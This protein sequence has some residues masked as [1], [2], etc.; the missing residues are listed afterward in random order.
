MHVN[1][2]R[3]RERIVLND[4]P[5]YIFC[6]QW[7][8]LS[9]VLAITLLVFSISPVAAQQSHVIRHHGFQEFSKGSFGD[10]GAN[11]YVSRNGLIQLIPRWDLNQDGYLDLLFNQD[12]NLIENVDAFIHWGRPEGY[13]SL[14][15]AFRKEVPAFKLVRTLQQRNQHLSFLPTFGGGSVKLVDLNRDDYVDIVFPNTIHNYYVDLDAY[16][17]WGGPKGYSSRRRTELPTLFAGDVAVADLNR[18][19]YPDLVFANYGD[20][21]GDRFGYKN[22]RYSYIYWGAPDGFSVQ[23][24]DQIPTLS[25]R[26]CTAGD[27]NGD[28]WPDLAFAN[29]SAKH[30]SLYVYLGGREGYRSNSRVI[31]EGGDPRVVRSADLNADGCSELIV[32]SQQ[33]MSNVYYGSR[34][35]QLKKPLSLPASNSRDAVSA[36]FNRDGHLDIAFASGANKPH[37]HA[38]GEVDATHAPLET[39]SVIFW[40]SAEGFDSRR[41]TMLPTLSPAAV[42][43]EDL[44]DDGYPEV[45][46]ANEHDGRT[47]DVPSYIYWGSEEGFDPSNRKHLQGFG[48]VGIGAADLNGDKRPEVVLMNPLSGNR[49]GLRSV[50][51]WGNRAHRYSEANATLLHTERPYFSKVADFND[52]GFRTWCFLGAP[53]TSTGEAH[54]GSNDIRCST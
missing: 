46:F 14:F 53:S 18:D 29:N 3:N 30:K 44:N 45:I 15:P 31:L 4:R 8:L 22:H 11:I 47:Y 34:D 42:A 48:P 23:R 16:I 6:D 43:A 1:S 26:S 7:R 12:H 35:F 40:G 17:Y 52:D 33:E 37:D 20:E 51:F 41:C 49:G 50:I 28:Q 54:K 32:C 2:V 27:F 38:P 10:G 39:E 21:S 36:D 13:H 25:A 24:R 5:A 19:D 9:F